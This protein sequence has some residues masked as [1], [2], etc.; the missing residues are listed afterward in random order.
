V[1][2]LCAGT[3][4]LGADAGLPPTARRDDG[5]ILDGLQAED[6]AAAAAEWLL[7]LARTDPDAAPAKNG[8]LSFFITEKPAFRTLDFEQAQPGGGFLRGISSHAEGMPPYA[9]GFERWSVPE[10]QRIGG[11][12]GL[13]RG[14]DLQCSVRASADLHRA[15]TTCGTL[16][17]LL[18][19]AWDRAHA[20][21][22]FG[23]SVFD[24][25]VT[26]W[27]LARM[28]T[29]VQSARQFTYAIARRPEAR[30]RHV[31]AAVARL[32]AS[33]V[34]EWVAREARRIDAATGPRT[35][36]AGESIHAG[37]TSGL[38]AVDDI[39]ALRVLG[40]ALL[41]EALE[42]DAA[43]RGRALRSRAA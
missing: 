28:A 4:H 36:N 1:V 30:R 34:A 41:E 10:A 8:G 7:V 14:L 20:R 12:R 5:W 35:T 22:L 39:L 38:D 29:L 24:H 27:K 40:R 26:Q 2:A 23:R 15:A 3:S 42:R 9:V 21:T 19:L 32:F 25:G 6:G 18:E 16:Q 13:G 43:K 31:E 17:R 33:R 37:A 11:D